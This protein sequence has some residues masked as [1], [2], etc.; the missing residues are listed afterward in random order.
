MERIKEYDLMSD[1]IYKFRSEIGKGG[2]T[3]SNKFEVVIQ[4]PANYTAQIGSHWTTHKDGL[5]IRAESVNA[6]GRNIASFDDSNIYGPLRQIPD[7]VTYADD[8]NVSFI[9]SKNLWERGFFD[10]WQQTIYDTETWNLRYYNDFIGK[11]AVYALD[12]NHTRTWG[13]V[14]HEVWPKTIGA[15]DFSMASLEIVKL[16]VNFA[17]RYWTELDDEESGE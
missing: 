2:I 12:R 15:A 10:G 6:A 1:W 17:F 13:M 4:P 11:L 8:V 9:L 3:E 5:V 14:Y 16:Q 7:G